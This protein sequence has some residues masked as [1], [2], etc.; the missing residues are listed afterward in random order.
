MTAHETTPTDVTTS[1]SEVLH[2]LAWPIVIPAEVRRT[3]RSAARAAIAYARSSSAASCCYPR[4]LY[5]S[6]PAMLHRYGSNAGSGEKHACARVI[7]ED[8]LLVAFP[9]YRHVGTTPSSPES[10]AV[11]RI[12]GQGVP[13]LRR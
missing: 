4:L 11:I 8:D 3:P 12:N 10:G 2:R 7:R 13:L 5:V 6:G 1:K 9:I